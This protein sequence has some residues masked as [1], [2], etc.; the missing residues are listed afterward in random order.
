MTQVKEVKAL[1]KVLSVDEWKLNTTLPKASE[2]VEIDLKET[3]KRIE[4]QLA[5]HDYSDYMSF[6]ESLWK[7]LATADILKWRKQ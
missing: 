6:R 5:L 1:V 3:R 7:E 4:K 2:C